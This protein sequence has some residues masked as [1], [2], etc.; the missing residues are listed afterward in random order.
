MTFLAAYLVIDN[1][2][3]DKGRAMNIISF[4]IMENAPYNNISKFVHMYSM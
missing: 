2:D 3:W 1:N 4:Q